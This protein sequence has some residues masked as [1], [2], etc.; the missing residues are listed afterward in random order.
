MFAIP[1]LMQKLWST[2]TATTILQTFSGVYKRVPPDWDKHRNRDFSSP[3]LRSTMFLV[4]QWALLYLISA[5]VV[6][7]I[8]GVISQGSSG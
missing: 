1:C 2:A 4:L 3:K 7:L 5:G 8:N 6:A